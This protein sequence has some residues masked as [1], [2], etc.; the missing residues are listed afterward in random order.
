M[1]V[2]MVSKKLVG[3]KKSQRGAALVEYAILIGAVTLVMLLGVSV[4]GHKLNDL[5]ATLAV[6]L[7]GAHEDDDVQL[8]SGKL[9]EYTA[10]AQGE[11]ASIDTS[12]IGGGDTARLANNLGVVNLDDVILD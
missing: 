10:G 4:M 8:V 3:S 5:T 9:V 11:T 1:E 2:T 7:P 12:S 6:L